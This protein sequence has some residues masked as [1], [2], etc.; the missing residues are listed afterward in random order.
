MN[1]DAQ[2]EVHPDGTVVQPQPEADHSVEQPEA[3]QPDLEQPEPELPE[4]GHML[5]RGVR[6]PAPLLPSVMEEKMGSKP[7]REPLRISARKKRDPNVDEGT[8]EEILGLRATAETRYGN[9]LMVAPLELSDRKGL[10]ATLARLWP[11][12]WRK[13]ADSDPTATRK[14][15]RSVVFHN[16]PLQHG[17][18]VPDEDGTRH[19]VAGINLMLHHWGDSH[20][21]N[22]ITMLLLNSPMIVEPFKRHLDEIRRQ[23]NRPYKILIDEIQDAALGDYQQGYD[24]KELYERNLIITGL[25]GAFIGSRG[26]SAAMGGLVLP[27]Q[28]FGSFL[29]SVIHRRPIKLAE[30]PLPPLEVACPIRPKWRHDYYILGDRA[31]RIWKGPF[32]HEFLQDLLDPELDLDIWIQCERVKLP[33][34]EGDLQSRELYITTLLRT[35]SQIENGRMPKF[36][37]VELRLSNLG[38][39]HRVT[40]LFDQLQKAF[41]KMI[42]GAPPLDPI[43]DYPLT[44]F[45]HTVTTGAD[46]LLHGLVSTVNGIGEIQGTHYWGKD[47]ETGH[48]VFIDRENYKHLLLIGKGERG[49]TTWDAALGGNQVGPFGKRVALTTAR[50]EGAINWVKHHGGDINVVS[51]ADAHTVEDQME[52]M[53]KVEAQARARVQ[54]K[55]KQW[56]KTGK[57][58]GMP[59]LLMPSIKS[60]AYSHYVLADLEEFN[61]RFRNWA[62]P[63]DDIEGVTPE[64]EEWE[65]GY[66]GYEWPTPPICSLTIED[67][68]AWPAL[69]KHE[70]LGMIPHDIGMRGRDW[71]VYALDG[72]HK[73]RIWFVATAHTVDQVKAFIEGFAESFPLELWFRKMP[74]YRIIVRNPVDRDEVYYN[75]INDIPDSILNVTGRQW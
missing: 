64:Y 5:A 16:R 73:D 23:G 7:Q 63:P 54:A 37:D 24:G 55:A 65:T 72:I 70:E 8:A 12:N 6:T 48:P 60:F 45:R 13:K 22:V 18:T 58:V 9:M 43:L 39:W 20:L 38:E 50:Q 51:I 33:W 75:L 57:F 62:V 31:Y 36:D 41:R 14:K 34:F 71:C 53:R 25:S 26:T 74:Y 28:L 67:I 2:A 19:V 61:L 29:H 66:A 49:K 27:Y 47:E 44:R 3:V 32:P 10:F 35:S 21:G 42:P 56:W 4:V 17:Y 40:G 15:W 69:T 52:L 11:S 30:R 46:E 59:E 1:T 68:Y